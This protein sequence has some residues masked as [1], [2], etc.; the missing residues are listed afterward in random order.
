MKPT[1]NPQLSRRRALLLGGAAFAGS[2]GLMSCKPQSDGDQNDL[3]SSLK[4]DVLVIG[5]GL[6]G[7]NAAYW[8]ESEGLNVTVLEA[9][10]RV[11]GRIKTL[12]HLETRPE[13]G[14]SQIGPM[15]ARIRSRINELGLALNTPEPYRPQAG[16]YING[17]AAN[18]RDWANDPL[19]KTVGDERHVLP[20]ALKGKYLRAAPPLENLSSWM[21]PQHAKSDIAFASFLRRE[22]ASEEAIRLIERTGEPTDDVSLLNQMRATRVR[23]FEMQ[24]GGAVSFLE[25][26]MSR[27]PEAMA[28]ALKRNVQ[29][30]KEVTNISAEGEGVQVKCADKSVYDAQFVLVTLPFSVL[31]DVTFN[32]PLPSVQDKAISKLPYSQVTQI[33]FDIDEPYWEE[34]GQ[35][36]SMFTDS[37]L[38]R[39]FALSANDKEN[40]TLWSFIDGQAAN[41]FP[42]MSEPEM[43]KWA[44]SELVKLRPSTKGRV[45]P[46]AT[47]SW[48]QHPYSKGAYAYFGPEQITAFK[49]SMALPAGPI[50]FAGEHTSDLSTGMEGAMESGE[51]AAFEIIELLTV[52]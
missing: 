44:Y 29:L 1:Q 43:L 34:D 7:L 41:E 51:R 31:R 40:Q 46:R 21:E 49:G 17:D 24:S 5:A 13:A 26:G 36:A 15:Y 25:G 4:N 2:T 3:T 20:F 11:G 28:R 23:A 8:L 16:F 30:N 10:N 42:K 33:F 14:G 45:T 22:G 9:D 18:L 37:P 12:G 48:S 35:P 6:S 38:G 52:K 39:L 19:N 27:L 32:P 50:H 47:W